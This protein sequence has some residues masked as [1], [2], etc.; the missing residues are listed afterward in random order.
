MNKICAFILI[1][2]S[3]LLVIAGTGNS[4]LV[5]WTFIGTVV[6]GPLKG[7]T[8]TGSFTY[9]GD[10]ISTTGHDSTTPNS[11][12]N[13]S[14]SF[15]FDNISYNETHDYD[16]PS[17]PAVDFENGVPSALIYWLEEGVNDVDFNYPTLKII[18]TSL[19]F[20]YSGTG[21]YDYE[22][23]LYPTHVPIPSAVWILGTGLIGIVGIRKR[24]KN[25]Q[26]I[27][28]C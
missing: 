15:V 3:I 11:D 21:E 4:E 22:T 24:L 16:Y 19:L 7:A 28:N 23:D 5:N 25:K 10:F 14:V 8:G 17:F 2:P 12:G 6:D 9:E 13:L 26:R 18:E 27:I 20:P 1:V